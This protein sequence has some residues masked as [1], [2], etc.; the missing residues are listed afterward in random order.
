MM[1]RC[2]ICGKHKRVG[3][4]VS[5]AHNK[6]KR[7][8]SPN[9]KRVRALVGRSRRRITICTSCLQAGKVIKAI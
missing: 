5:H 4:S 3:N 9:L 7:Y 1:R 2:E 6:T 8:F